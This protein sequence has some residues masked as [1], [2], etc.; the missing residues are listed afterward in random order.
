M[1]EYCKDGVRIIGCPK[2][3]NVDLGKLTSIMMRN[4]IKSIS[5]I[6]MEVPCCGPLAMKVQDAI[7]A[8][9]KSIPLTIRIIGRDGSI[10]T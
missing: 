4:D 2:L 9:G 7:R 10:R 6:R 3:G 1:E 5:L 8:S